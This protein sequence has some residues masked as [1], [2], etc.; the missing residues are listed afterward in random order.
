[1]VNSIKAD[2]VIETILNILN[3]E[4]ILSPILNDLVPNQ[5]DRSRS[6]NG[7][8]RKIQYSTYNAKL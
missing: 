8:T 7:K 6:I 5:I 4:P 1:M 3:F 2:I